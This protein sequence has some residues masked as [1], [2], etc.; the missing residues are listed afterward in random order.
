MKLQNTRLNAEKIF[1]PGNWKTM[2]VPKVGTLPL[3]NLI[4]K[5]KKD[6]GKYQ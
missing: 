1:I 4:E 3:E 2:E 6:R 5:D